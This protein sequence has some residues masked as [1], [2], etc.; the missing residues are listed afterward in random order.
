MQSAVTCG[1]APARSAQAALICGSQIFLSTG[2]ISSGRVKCCIAFQR[3]LRPWG[4]RVSN[5]TWYRTYLCVQ[6]AFEQQL[7]FLAG[8]QRM[9]LQILAGLCNCTRHLLAGPALNVSGYVQW[10]VKAPNR[11]SNTTRHLAQMR[12][13]S[14]H[15][16]FHSSCNSIAWGMTHQEGLHTAGVSSSAAEPESG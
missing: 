1:F 13:L 9:L 10:C 16:K 14:T 2:H 3:S 7:H 8:T 11:I 12:C 5:A 15:H 4:Q 6:M